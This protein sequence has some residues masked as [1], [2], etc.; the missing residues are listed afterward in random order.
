MF[1]E[2]LHTKT[3][4]D[5]CFR[6]RMS[7]TSSGNF[8]RPRCLSWCNIIDIPKTFVL[9]IYQETITI[10]P[11]LYQHVKQKFQ[12]SSREDFDVSSHV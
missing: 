2:E 9:L 1:S 8:W 10:R 5:I 4:W 12:K 3:D 11:A 6:E 7:G